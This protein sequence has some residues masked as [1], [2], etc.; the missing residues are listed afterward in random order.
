MTRKLP[1]GVEIDACL[2]IT[3]TALPSDFNYNDL[4]YVAV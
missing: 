3:V 1:Y 2:T 4:E